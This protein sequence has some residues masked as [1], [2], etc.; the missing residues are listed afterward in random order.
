MITDRLH[1]LA[2]LVRV[3]NLGV[4]TKFIPHNKPDAIFAQLGL[5]ASGMCATVRSLLA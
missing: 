2:P 3:E 1:T 5:D 4:P